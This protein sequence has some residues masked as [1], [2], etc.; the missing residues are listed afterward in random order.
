MRATQLYSDEY[1]EKSAKLSVSER[2]EFL[3]EYRQLLPLSV[4][5]EALH[6]RRVAWER[7]AGLLHAQETGKT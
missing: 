1:I 4:F 5:E 3:E 2:L 6:A 7:S